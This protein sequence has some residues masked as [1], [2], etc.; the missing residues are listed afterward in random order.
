MTTDE[1]MSRYSRRILEATQDAQEALI[2]ALDW[3]KVSGLPYEERMIFTG[4]IL[5][6]QASTIRLL[7]GAHQYRMKGV[8]PEF[9][10]VV[11]KLAD[12]AVNNAKEMGIWPPS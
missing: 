3:V 9:A 8:P 11:E 7:A 1:A 2:E 12:D 10:A 5:A 4:K 6:L